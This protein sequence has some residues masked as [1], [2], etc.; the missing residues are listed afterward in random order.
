MV[1]ASKELW[2]TSYIELI[3]AHVKKF[4]PTALKV[5]FK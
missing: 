5:V 4:G 2:R 1:G 3:E